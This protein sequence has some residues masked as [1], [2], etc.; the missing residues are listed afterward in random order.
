M[1]IR[2]KLTGEEIALNYQKWEDQYLPRKLEN[3][4]E[5]LEQDIVMLMTIDSDGQRKPYRKFERDHA[6]RMVG[7]DHLKYEFKE[8]VGGLIQGGIVKNN[9]KL[10]NAK[11]GWLSQ[12]ILFIITFLF[13]KTD[14]QK[15]KTWIDNNINVITVFV[16]ILTLLVTVWIAYLQGA[17]NNIH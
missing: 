5:I 11:R 9:N 17:F 16:A 7:S 15:I 3:N 14:R 12:A 4:F 6:I 2:N 10:K 1:I 13:R 8:I